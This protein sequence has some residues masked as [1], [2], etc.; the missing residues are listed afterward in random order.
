MAGALNL[1]E[2]VTVVGERAFYNCSKLTSLTLPSTLTTIGSYAFYSCSSI[3]GTITIPSKVTSF[4]SN[5]FQN[6]TGINGS[7]I[8]ESGVTN[9]GNYAFNGCSNATGALNIPGT[10]T[11]FGS[12]AFAG[13]SKLTSLTIES[14]VT[15]IGSNAFNNC[16]GLT[17]TIDIPGTVT[18]I[19]SYAFYDCDGIK[20]VLT[21]TGLTSIGTYSFQGCGA[22]TVVYIA[23]SVTS[24]SASSKTYAPFYN[25]T[26]SL[27]IYCGAS[28]KPSGWGSYWNYRSNNYTCTT[29]W[30]CTRDT[31]GNIKNS[32]GTILAS[33]T[34]DGTNNIFVIATIGSLGD[35]KLDA[36]DVL[37]TV[38]ILGSVVC[39]GYVF[40]YDA[41][42]KAANKQNIFKRKE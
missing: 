26:S 8:I 9:I 5:A 42:K 3:A 28:S 11:S 10:V 1:P 39:M 36:I 40:V 13:C 27:K 16:D 33:A 2:G 18:S 21:N 29:T 23:G 20:K 35:G 34:S 37:L 41:N 25:C 22:L 14:G 30:N 6:C 24:I 7:I 17:G 38:L 15:S 12:Y 31:S 32:S 19:G 4:G